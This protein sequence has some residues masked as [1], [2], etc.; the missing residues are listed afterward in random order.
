MSIWLTVVL[1]INTLFLSVIGFGVACMAYMDMQEYRR[2]KNCKPPRIYCCRCDAEIKEEEEEDE[3]ACGACCGV[4][5]DEEKGEVKLVKVSRI[6]Q[7]L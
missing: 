5:E 1:I 6:F 2:A 3:L 7:C 4:D